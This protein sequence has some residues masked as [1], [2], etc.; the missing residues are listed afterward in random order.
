MGTS[1]PAIS[2]LKS[3]ATGRLAHLVGALGCYLVKYVDLEC[4]DLFKLRIQETTFTRAKKCDCKV[5][6]MDVIFPM[7]L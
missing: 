7:S 3:K 4:T 6:R 2:A 5:L 1:T